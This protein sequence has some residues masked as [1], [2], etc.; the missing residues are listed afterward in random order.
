MSGDILPVQNYEEAKAKQ[1]VSPEA[2]ADSNGSEAAVANL[3]GE[4]IDSPDVFGK[5]GVVSSRNNTELD[6]PED[7]AGQLDE[8]GITAPTASA[9]KTSFQSA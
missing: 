1:P 5:L 4:N 9:S 6:L 8:A 3:P 7:V 2:P